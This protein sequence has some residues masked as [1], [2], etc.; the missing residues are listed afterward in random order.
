MN[1]SFLRVTRSAAA[2]LLAIALLLSVS[3]GSRKVTI[4]PY[5][6]TYQPSLVPNPM[7]GF[8]SFYR[9]K[10]EKIPSDSSLEYIGLK[11]SE[12][13][14]WENGKSTVNPHVLDPMLEKI[15]SRGHNAILRVY[16]LYPGYNSENCTGLFLP[17]AL[18]EA[19][20]KEGDIYASQYE[21]SRLEY[22]DFN[23]ETLL[24]A[25]TD[26]IHAFG[27][28]YD[29][30]PVIAAVQMGLYG[31]W[32]E[33]NMAG[34]QNGQ[35]AMTDDNLNS[36]IEAYTA[37]FR[38]TKLMARNPSLGR[39]YDYPIGFHDDNFM[40]NSS[41]FH[42]QNAEWKALLQKQN[43]TYGTL[44]Q[45]Y[46]FIDGNGGK[47]DPIWDKWETQMFGGELSGQMYQPPFGPLWSGTEH[48]ALLYCIGQFHVSWIMGVGVDGIP[49]TDSAEYRDYLET[50]GAFGYDIGLVSTESKDRFGKIT[51]TLTNYGV[52]PFYYDW[53]I[54]YWLT[55]QDGSIIFTYRDDE[56]RLSKLLPETTAQS[57]MLLPEDLKAGEYTACLRFV[58]SSE[59]VSKKVMPLRLANDHAVRDGVYEI[60][61]ITIE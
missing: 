8:A 12:I 36:L 10:D 61:H 20:K 57:E 52:A 38:R 32:G 45:F 16:M 55:D 50:A 27:K 31:S 9:E 41:D 59:S 2:C 53:P 51:V 21:G 58:N 1:L 46:D 29:G 37:A 47:Y 40:F 18:Y 43:R 4:T 13:C 42:K 26:F 15:A 23:N 22:P 24:T 60:A 30:N 17:D 35:C 49:A 34:C 25:M 19:V 44:Q 54:E 39:A 3:C 11:F 7:K 14:T 48:E 6:F 5:E 56:F 33:W 28:Q